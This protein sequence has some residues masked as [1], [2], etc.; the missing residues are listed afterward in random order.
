MS[1]VYSTVQYSSTVSG[2]C[3]V[4]TKLHVFQ[5]PMLVVASLVGPSA[6]LSAVVLA[7][8]FYIE[9]LVDV[10]SVHDLFAFDT[11]ELLFITLLE[12]AS[13]E[14]VTCNASPYHHVSVCLF[15]QEAQLSQRPRDVLCH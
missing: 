4:I 9:H 15:Q 8:T 5:V 2:I 13:V 3:S 7:F 10:I 14:T 6:H 12:F 11:P 1:I